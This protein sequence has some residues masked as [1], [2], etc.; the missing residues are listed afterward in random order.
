MKHRLGLVSVSFRQHTPKEILIAMK[1]CGLDIIEWG[2]DLHAPIHKVSEI[3]KLQ[4]EYQVTCCS[5]GSYFRLGVTPLTELSN[6]L[7][8]AKI[9]GTNIVRVWCGDKN[10][11]EYS[12]VEKAEFFEICRQ[13]ADIAKKHNAVICMECHNNTFTDKKESAAM[14]MKKVNNPN[15]KMYWQP[16]QFKSF[17]ENLA[18]AK[19]L[20]EYTV[21]LHVFNWRGDEKFPLIKGID[22]WRE[23][24]TCFNGQKNLLLEFMPDGKLQSLKSEA[25][26]LRQILNY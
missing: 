17:N 24:L 5:Y 9:L 18:Y 21:N 3:A 8:A 6:Y 11:E 7:T 26:A 10:S 25:D 12:P 23:Y 19:L 1:E 2:S 4:K 22:D 20:G 14:L 15:F 16:N 13:S